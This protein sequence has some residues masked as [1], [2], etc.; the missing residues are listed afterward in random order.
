MQSNRTR[1]RVR[2]ES[3]RISRLC[4]CRWSL[5]NVIMW[6]V[7]ELDVQFSWRAICDVVMWNKRHYR[8]HYLDEWMW[9]R[10][11]KKFVGK[12][13]REEWDQAQA[14]TSSSIMLIVHRAQCTTDANEKPHIEFALIC[15]RSVMLLDL[16]MSMFVHVVLFWWCSL[17]HPTNVNCVIP[18]AAVLFSTFSGSFSLCRWW[19]FTKDIQRHSWSAA[20]GWCLLSMAALFC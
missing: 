12:V 18:F 15:K 20:M 10:E 19:W 13:E 14:C 1:T 2:A 17:V 9:K 7:L 5:D 8:C 4:G 11:Q 6:T 16:R 3:H